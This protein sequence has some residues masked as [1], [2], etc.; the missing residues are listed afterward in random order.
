[1][2]N[3]IS[4]SW[5]G[6]YS[7]LSISDFNGVMNSPIQ[8]QLSK[9]N[10]AK[11]SDLSAQKRVLAEA[12]NKSSSDKSHGNQNIHGIS[13]MS[14]P[15]IPTVSP[16]DHSN[17]FVSQSNANPCGPYGADRRSAARQVSISYAESIGSLS[18]EA[19]CHQ[20]R[21]PLAAPRAF[22]PRSPP[23]PPS[24]LAAPGP[25]HARWASSSIPTAA[26]AAAAVPAPAEPQLPATV[27]NYWDVDPFRADWPHW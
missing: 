9:D 7:S 20:Q 15:T 21:I 3:E 22:A 25:A 8:D 18:N 27:A 24:P 17:H 13:Q 14:F 11:F 26:A 6:L 23:P 16:A 1:V 12:K 4:L 10:D 19:I 5:T 2:W